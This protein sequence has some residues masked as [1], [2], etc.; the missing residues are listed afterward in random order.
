[1]RFIFALVFIFSF[2]FHTR[3]QIISVVYDFD[4]MAIGSSNLPDGDFSN[5]DLTYEAVANPLTPSDVLGDRVLKTKL[6]WNAG[7]GE[8]GKATMRFIELNAGTDLLNF[9]LYNPVSNSAS[10]NLKVIITEDDNQNNTYEDPS[11]DKWTYTLTVSRS[12]AW[13]L[14]S[15]PLSSFIDENPGGNSTFDAAYTN[16]AGMLFSIG[17]VFTKPD[18]A[19]VYDEYFLDMI[20]FTEGAMP[21]GA[22][23]LDLPAANP[24]ANIKLGALT[25]NLAPDQVPAEVHAMLPPGKKLSFVNWFVFYADNGTAANNLPGAEV[26]NLISQGYKP[27]ITW[28]SMFKEY[29]RLDPVQPKLNNIVNGSFDTYIDAFANQIKSYSGTVIL[30]ILHEFEGDWYSW[31]LTHNG[32][33]PALYIQAYR[34]IVDRF[35]TLGA[36][37]VEWMWCVNA[38]P[39][40]YV[41]YNWI[42][43]CY[44]GDNYVDIIATDIY[45]HPDLGTPAWKSFRYTMSESYYYLTKNF[46]NKPLYVCEVGCRERNSSEA[47]AQ[48]KGDWLCM[49]NKDLK[50]YFNKTQ[51]LI[52]FS[53]VKEHDWRINST[54]AAKQSFIDCIWSDALYGE[55]VTVSEVFT[56]DRLNIYPNPFSDA[57]RILLPQSQQHSVSVKVYDVTGKIVINVPNANS[58]SDFTFGAELLDGVYIV[59]VNDGDRTLRQ[60]VIKS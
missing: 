43:N 50:T 9:Y 33:D 7:V 56:Y 40:P 16:A 2:S 58:Q 45:N 55:P 34:H 10:A 4:G 59:E 8:F 36:T 37:N 54:N 23:I 12:G 14:F 35:N 39:K 30:R 57:I 49:M 1:M 15:V 31:S 19:S 32:Q 29:P 20:C 22:G 48:A 21:T 52:F 38:E 28:E 13:Q 27:V 41:A 53:I 26:Q 24:S 25:A 11:D 46:P 3:A 42:K 6:N 5:N 60:K 44:P 18:P 51:A 47:L 17:F